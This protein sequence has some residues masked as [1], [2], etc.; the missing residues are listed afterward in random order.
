MILAPLSIIGIS[1]G[2]GWLECN[3]GNGITSFACI[4]GWG[5]AMFIS[6]FGLAGF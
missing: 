5:F 2:I 6:F 3:A 1:S 4:G